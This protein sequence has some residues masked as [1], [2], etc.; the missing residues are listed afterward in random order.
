LASWA[1]P[2][3]GTRAKA[4]NAMTNFHIHFLPL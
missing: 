3:C 1:L 4:A 2:G